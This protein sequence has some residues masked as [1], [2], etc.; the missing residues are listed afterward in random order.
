[1]SKDCSTALLAAANTVLPFSQSKSVLDIGCGRGG[2]ISAL[3][4]TYGTSVPSVPI[5]AIDSSPGMIDQIQQRLKEEHPTWTSVKTEIRDTTDLSG[6]EDNS[7]SHVISGFTLYF[8]PPKALEEAYRVTSP[9]G[10]LATNAMGSTSWWNMM[11]TISLIKPDF[12]LPGMPEAWNTVAAMT[13]TLQNVGLKD[14]EVKEMEIGLPYEDA[15]E[16]AIFIIR[17]MPYTD[18]M[19][20][21]FTGKERTR[22][23]AFCGDWVRK[24]CEGGKMR[25]TAFVGVGRK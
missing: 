7:F 25:G 24:E 18:M 5:T 4:S 2:N 6:F 13:K 10:V 23:K 9:G 16:M 21:G 8:L 14:V 11:S 19:T 3:L 22:W 17:T 12:K 15:D 1:M 20:S